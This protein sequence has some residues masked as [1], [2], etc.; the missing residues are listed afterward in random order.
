M[1]EASQQ[2]WVQPQRQSN[3]GDGSQFPEYLKQVRQLGKGAYGTV[4]LCEDT[5]Q[6]GTRVAVKHIKQAA[7]HGKS[8]LREVQLLARL[9][10]ENLLHI[11]DFA[12]VPGPNFEEVYI[13]LPYMPTDLHKLIQSQQSLTDKHVQVIVCQILRALAYLHSAGVAH[14]DLKPA[15]ILLIA[16]CRLKICDFGLARGNMADPESEE[17]SS[18]VLT[19]YVVTRWYRAPEVMLLPKQYSTALDIWAVGCILCEIL[20]RR[21]LFPGKNHVDM[22]SRVCQ[23]LGTPPDDQL[24]W[25]PRKS[26]AYRFLKNVCPQTPG[27]PFA[28]LYPMASADCLDLVHGLLQWDPS[29]RITASDAQEHRYLCAFL[30]KQRPEPPEHFDWSFDGFKA[31]TNAV[32]ERL[33][34][35]CARFHPE[36]IERDQPKTVESDH[37]A[38]EKVHL[39]PKSGLRGAP[40]APALGRG[41]GIGGFVASSNSS[42]PQ[43]HY[44]SAGTLKET[45]RMGAVQYAEPV[46]SMPAQYSSPAHRTEK[47]PSR[48]ASPAPHSNVAALT[49]KAS[50]RS[51]TPVRYLTPRRVSTTCAASGY[52]PK[53]PSSARSQVLVR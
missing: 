48:R 45:P 9:K 29:K 42:T 2:L 11:L 19:E 10:H 53:P 51:L 15:N 47:V 13:V 37:L 7:R 43:S 20:G 52:C 25:L 27:T 49:A 50:V 18:G 3:S 21:A 6:A 8:I 22:V 38:R 1:P 36:I 28:T 30:P 14:R 40:S 4:Y 23:V 5:K 46:Q 33:Y 32:R 26:D 44:R 16:D 41:A 12:P 39:T 17:Q 34:R 35:E 31:T 24:E